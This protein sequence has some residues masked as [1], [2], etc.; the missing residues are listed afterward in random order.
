M[1]NTPPAEIQ[2][3]I[4]AQVKAFNSHDDDLFFGV[5]GDSASSSTVSPYRRLNRDG[6]AHW[7]AR[8]LAR[9]I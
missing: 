1:T 5:F 6:P 9:A 2:N 4:E 7:L 3:P 8:E